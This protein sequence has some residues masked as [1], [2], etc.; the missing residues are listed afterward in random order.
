M[1]VKLNSLYNRLAKYEPA[2][3][4]SFLQDY[5]ASSETPDNTKSGFH[6]GY[7][8]LKWLIMTVRNMPNA[9]N[10]TLYQL[11]YQL[12]IEKKALDKSDHSLQHKILSYNA[13]R[14]Y[15]NIEKAEL[16][17]I[18]QLP[19]ITVGKWQFIINSTQ[20]N[21]TSRIF[22]HTRADAVLF[23]NPVT[24]AAGII[25][26]VNSQ[27][28]KM[29]EHKAKTFLAFGRHG[30]GWRTV[31]KDSDFNLIINPGSEEPPSFSGMAMADMIEIIEEIY[32]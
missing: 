4:S 6:F 5:C 20:H 10:E 12:V 26:R 30:S 25:Y 9:D 21:L 22:K 15:R 14:E 8:S 19:Q 11:F 17:E 24:E 23:N 32:K 28:N 1:K 3:V 16:P 27:L 2:L 13:A 7:N 31:G 29:L 18:S